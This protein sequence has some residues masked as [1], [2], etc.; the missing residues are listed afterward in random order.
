[1]RC[2]QTSSLHLRRFVKLPSSVGI[3]PLDSPSSNRCN[4]ERSPKLDGMLPLNLG[5]YNESISDG[6]ERET[7]AVMQFPHGSRYVPKL[8]SWAASVGKLPEMKVFP[9]WRTSKTP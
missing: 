8:V 4:S 9:R 6:K 5:A 1:M 2:G 3:V 7:S